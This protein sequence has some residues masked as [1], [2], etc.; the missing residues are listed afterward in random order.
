MYLNNEHADTTRRK[1]ESLKRNR[2]IREYQPW[3][4]RVEMDTESHQLCIIE[5]ESEEKKEKRTRKR[6]HE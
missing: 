5:K 3:F 4:I 2:K 6:K 1:E